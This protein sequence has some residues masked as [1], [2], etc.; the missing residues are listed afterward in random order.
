[1]SITTSTLL[2]SNLVLSEIAYHGR[3]RRASYH[4][5]GFALCPASIDPFG[6]DT[7]HSSKELTRKPN[8]YGGCTD[9][10]YARA[11]L[12]SSREGSSFK[13]ETSE[14]QIER[15]LFGDSFSANFWCGK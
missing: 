9:A 4:A 5:L 10:G 3:Q 1:M 13:K 15:I 14:H 2:I 12:Q 6:S 7:L 8:T 11:V